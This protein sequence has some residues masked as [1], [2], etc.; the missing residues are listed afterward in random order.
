MF[1]FT[2]LLIVSNIVALLIVTAFEHFTGYLKLSFSSDYAFYSMLILLAIG[3][4]MSFSGH[5]VGYSDPSN[6]AGVSA[7]SLIDNE[8]AKSTI[9]TKL[10]STSVGHSLLI[11]SLFPLLYCLLS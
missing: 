8:S 1:R 4:L 2:R 6:I 11:A 9:V 3:T 10:E 7:S 5:K